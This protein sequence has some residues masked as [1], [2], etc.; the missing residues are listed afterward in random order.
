MTGDRQTLKFNKPASCWTEAFPL[1]NGS[2]GAMVYGGC[3]KDILKM[4]QDTLWTGHPK[5]PVKT[6]SAKYFEEVR[7]L[8]LEGRLMEAQKIIEKHCQGH[9]S[10]LYLPLGDVEI[11]FENQPEEAPDYSRELNFRD[12]LCSVSYSGM[13][14]EYF[15]SYP[16]GIMAIQISSEIPVSYGISMK[17][18][19]KNQTSFAD[20][21]FIMDG[22]CPSDCRA[23]EL[24]YETH[25]LRYSDKPEEKGVPFRSVISVKSDG[26]A[27]YSESGVSVKNAK[28]SLVVFAVETGFNG[29]DKAPQVEG[30]EY[31]NAALCK[32]RA[33]AEKGF[34]A[35]KEEHISDVREVYDRVKFELDGEEN[36]KYVQFYN[37]GRYLAIAASRPG[38]QPMNLQG[39]WNWSEDPPWRC[40]YTTNI[41]TEMNYWP[42]FMCN[43]TELS[44]PLIEMI[45]DISVQGKDTAENI[46]GAKGF[47]AHHNS[48]LWRHTDPVGVNFFEYSGE[49]SFWYMS[50]VW[51][52]RHLYE[53]YEYTLDEA[54]A[55][56]T[57]IP[58]MK[59]A[60]EFC[61]SML[62]KDKDGKLIMVP[63]TSPE[64][65]F[66]SPEGD[67]C[68]V[69]QTTTMTMSLVKD[70]FGNFIK[71]AE[72]LETE[73]E[74]T[75]K[76]KNILPKLLE[77]KIGDD[78][79]L[80]EWYQPEPEIE[81]QHRHVSHLYG[82]HPARLIT[83]DE[84]PELAEACKK[85]LEFRGDEGTGWSL[86]WKINIWARLKDGDH[87]LKLLERQLMQVEEK[88]DSSHIG[89]T[90]P[91]LFDA[92][93]PFQIDGN[94]GAVS[95][96]TEM[97]MQS[98]DDKIFI[99]P[100]LPSQWKNGRI[101]G[102][103]AK[104]NIAVSI[105]W[106][107]G[108]VTEYKL[109]GEISDKEIIVRDEK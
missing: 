32:T 10:Q 64:N 84:T 67:R 20:D 106:K 5:K 80:L 65:V 98:Y 36:L 94:F 52:S 103:K 3:D 56:E 33:A 107:D 89:G 66:L 76:I 2:I 82:L 62:R 86:G 43:M 63:S 8:A 28:E 90:Y 97:L 24:T 27:E 48:D 83:P 38:S 16:A 4:N 37:F 7:K 57:A 23:G 51:L 78:G 75:E 41:N 22:E 30:K 61:E 68:A 91:N 11:D 69:S 105:E 77:F 85:S 26:E 79:R 109:D 13:K 88:N 31:K 40:N 55:K 1:G 46:Y 95:G 72:K 70:L 44:L 15:I 6:D 17:S 29:Y 59:S 81:P 18:V 42:M 58:I 53:Y 34:A 25:P 50:G 100:A 101:S 9:W 93:P 19:L 99:L 39:I 21:C 60:C 102:L 74:F 92:H 104:G 108:K 54:F 73:K 47:A 96:I 45:K 87:A 35:L 14:R 71:L 49:W 12:S